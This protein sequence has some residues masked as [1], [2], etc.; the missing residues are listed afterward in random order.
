M[1][2]GFQQPV[3]VI[4]GRI[5][6]WV[7]DFI[8]TSETKKPQVSR[9]EAFS[10]ISGASAPFEPGGEVRV[11][12]GF[13]RLSLSKRYTWDTRQPAAGV[14]SFGFSLAEKAD[15]VRCSTPDER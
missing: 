4:F 5:Q 6:A 14:F 3:G 2:T 7:P 10:F 9:P 11:F 12:K 13:G 1:I 15:E 8:G